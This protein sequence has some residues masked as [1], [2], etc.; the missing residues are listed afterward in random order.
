MMKTIR[1]YDVEKRRGVKRF[2]HD[3]ELIKVMTYDHRIDAK[4]AL[5]DFWD[6]VKRAGLTQAESSAVNLVMECDVILPIH[7]E[8]VFDDACRK[9]AKVFKKQNYGRME[10]TKFC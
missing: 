1:S 6:A 4:D 5:I 3:S 2:I 9:I 8:V 10:I 7:T